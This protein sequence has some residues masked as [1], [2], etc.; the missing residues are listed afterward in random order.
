MTTYHVEGEHTLLYHQ[1]GDQFH[2]ILAGK[3]TKGGRNWKDGICLPDTASLRP[4]TLNDFEA[5]DVMP[6]PEMERAAME[7][8]PNFGMF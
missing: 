8:L 2:G 5:F 1:P 7:S 4:A 6:P 3:I